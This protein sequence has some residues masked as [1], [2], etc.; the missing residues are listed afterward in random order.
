[1]EITIKVEPT[2][3]GRYQATLTGVVSPLDPEW[4]HAVGACS[5]SCKDELESIKNL[6][7]KLEIPL[8]HH[9]WEVKLLRWNIN[10]MDWKLKPA[11][12]EQSPASPEPVAA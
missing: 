7:G 12:V 11:A 8:S 9:A 1:M 4:E 10:A 6:M 5:G 2:L 3:A